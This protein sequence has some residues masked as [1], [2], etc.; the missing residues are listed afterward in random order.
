MKGSV[1]MHDVSSV[2]TAPHTPQQ[3]ASR[4]HLMAGL[5]ELTFADELSVQIQF[6]SFPPTKGLQT[7]N[8]GR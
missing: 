3:A 4:S 7:K 6:E 8:K 5:T 2:A 1:M